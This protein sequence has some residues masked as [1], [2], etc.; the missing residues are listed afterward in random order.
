MASD[1][2]PELAERFGRRILARTY[3]PGRLRAVTLGQDTPRAAHVA[4]TG[5]GP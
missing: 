1:W 2:P 3:Q 4:C 5:R